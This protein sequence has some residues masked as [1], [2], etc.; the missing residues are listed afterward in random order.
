MESENFK[1]LLESAQVDMAADVDDDEVLL[2]D[3]CPPSWEEIQSR[4]SDKE[5]E[6][7]TMKNIGHGIA[8]SKPGFLPSFMIDVKNGI[9][10]IA[11]N[12]WLPMYYIS[13]LFPRLVIATNQ[14]TLL[15]WTPEGSQSVTITTEDPISNMLI[16]SIG[17]LVY[18]FYATTGGELIY[19]LASKF[20]PIN[21]YP[22]LAPTISLFQIDNTVLLATA[23][24]VLLYD[25]DDYSQLRETRELP[26]PYAFVIL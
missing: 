21:L 8:P 17:E 23:E 13:R 15:I 26:S 1:E 5:H 25:F 7:F 4:L 2:P 11:Y 3:L 16:A 24:V 6:G 18:I 12:A 10:A 19:S 9:L 22:P 20:V 14:S